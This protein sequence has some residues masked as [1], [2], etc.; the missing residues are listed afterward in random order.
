MHSP[1]CSHYYNIVL[2]TLQQQCSKIIIVA[3]LVPTNERSE[4]SYIGVLLY[5]SYRYMVIRLY[6][7]VI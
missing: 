3:F 6:H 4:M 2:F 5:T 1:S 7:D